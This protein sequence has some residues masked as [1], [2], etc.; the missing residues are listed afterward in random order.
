MSSSRRIRPD[1][2]AQLVERVDAREPGTQPPDT[3]P[4]GFPSLDNA[5][6]G[7]FR[8]QDLVV[9]GGDVGAG[10]SALAIGMALRVARAGF[11]VAYLSGE[12]DEDRLLERALALEGRV[13]I[14][15]MRCATLAEPARAAL[16]SAAF[17]LRDLPM[18]V[19]PL[20]GPTFGDVI[21]DLE[22]DN[23]SMIVLDYL[24]LLAPPERRQT[25]D[26]DCAASI[27]ALKALALERHVVCLTVSQLPQLAAERA[28]RR[29]NLDDFGALG[30][31]KQHAD[32]VLGLYREEMYS[33]GPDVAGATE[34]IIA[35]NRNGPTGFVDLYFHRQWLRFE[36][37]LDPDR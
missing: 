31:V 25:H 26:E 33:T 32:V 28:D 1:S 5:L 8:R 14:D 35:K 17:R 34:L 15:E 20:S 16:G 4:S 12:M 6:G 24:Q 10:K 22:P 21:A 19:F 11:P 29:P 36:D 18:R 2:L 23:P 3:I 7:G 13:Q 37:M 30:S 27:R 9:L